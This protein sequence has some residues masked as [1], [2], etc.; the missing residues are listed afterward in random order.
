MHTTMIE[1]QASV[2]LV[3]WDDVLS[4]VCFVG[5]FAYIRR[6]MTNPNDLFENFV[7]L[8][9]SVMQIDCRSLYYNFPT[10]GWCLCIESKAHG[11]S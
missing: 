7:T 1:M 11:L 5:K 6:V 9:R 4:A 10:G 2:V 3:P 8:L